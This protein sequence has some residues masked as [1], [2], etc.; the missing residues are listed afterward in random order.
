MHEFSNRLILVVSSIM[1]FLLLAELT[2]R[3]SEPREIMRYFFMTNDELL[4]HRFVPHGRGFFKTTEFRTEY[5][6]NSLGLRDREFSVNKPDSVVR[7]LMLGDSF[8][9]GNGVNSNQTFSKRLEKMLNTAGLPFGCEVIN[10]GVGSYSPLP[11]YLYLKNFGLQLQPDIVILNFDLSDVYDD[12]QYTA[13]AKFDDRGVPIGITPQRETVSSSWIVRRLVGI[14]NFFKEH[15]QLYNFIRIRLDM[16]LN[17][18]ANENVLNGDFRYDKYALLKEDGH[19]RGP[20]EWTLSEKYLFMIRD[21]LRAH[22]IEFLVCVYPYGLQVSPREWIAGRAYWSFK[23]D[24]VYSMKPQEFLQGLCEAHGI[25]VI[26]LCSDFRERSKQIYPL[27]YDYNGHW[28]PEGHEVAA[29]GMFRA[30]KPLL[31][32]KDRH[33]H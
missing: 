24:T 28:K 7:I 13:R 8:T 12:I 22:G 2:V 20:E 27:Y 11:E 17:T 1:V 23:Q 15:T 4:D 21:T 16:Y 10:A 32:K 6:I 26:N 31:M 3:L 29:A 5:V 19:S 14:K 25:N 30:L 33:H 18:P 9:E